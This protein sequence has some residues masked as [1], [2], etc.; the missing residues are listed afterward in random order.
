MQVRWKMSTRQAGAVGCKPRASVAPLW[1]P[2]GVQSC[3]LPD[4]GVRC[5]IWKVR[6]TNPHL[7]TL[8]LLGHLR[9]RGDYILAY[10]ESLVNACLLVWLVPP[11][12][13]PFVISGYLITPV[14]TCT[15]EARAGWHWQWVQWWRWWRWVP[16]MS[17]STP[18]RCRVVLLGCP[19]E[20]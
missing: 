17:Q 18:G 5:P 9:A 11:S 10:H 1:P 8:Q 19:A 15:E 4:S 13:E 7:R 3:G 12:G 14:G 16:W 20:P 6:H 2:P